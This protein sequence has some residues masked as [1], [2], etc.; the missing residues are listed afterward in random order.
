[1]SSVQIY[2]KSSSSEELLKQGNKRTQIKQTKQVNQTN[3]TSTSGSHKPRRKVKLRFLVLL[4][5]LLMSTAW[6]QGEQ[7]SSTESVTQ[8]L[9]YDVE[10]LWSMKQDWQS[11]ATNEREVWEIRWQFYSPNLQAKDILVEKLFV[12]SPYRKVAKRMTNNGRTITAQVRDLGQISIHQMT[13]EQVDIDA[14][15][16]EERH[17]N[18]AVIWST[19]EWQEDE[20]ITKQQVVKAVKKITQLITDISTETKYSIKVQLATAVD[21]SLAQLTREAQAIEVVG[22]DN[23]DDEQL[24]SGLYYTPLIKNYLFMSDGSK[25][26]IQFALFSDPALRHARLTIGVPAISGEF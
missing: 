24:A 20:A 23:Y 9:Q 5:V 21:Q 10:Q 12:D 17:H 25:A 13:D 3:R 4:L 2:C 1:M 6:L 7:V 11:S 16:S 14:I 26:N 19:N 8:L 18:M 15:A 22:N